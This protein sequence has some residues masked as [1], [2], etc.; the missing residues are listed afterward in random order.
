MRAFVGN[1]GCDQR[2]PAKPWPHSCGVLRNSGETT[3]V[4]ARKSGNLNH[5]IVARNFAFETD[6][7][8]KIANGQMENENGLDKALKRQSIIVAAREMGCLMKTDLVNGR[9]VKVFKNAGGK[10]DRCSPGSRRDRTRD[11]RL[12]EIQSRLTF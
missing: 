2:L 12:R 11:L 10:D 3:G 8:R 9:I 6:L 4:V 1:R 5:E 7:V